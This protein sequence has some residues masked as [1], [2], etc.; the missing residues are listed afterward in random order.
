MQVRN[1]HHRVF[2]VQSLDQVGELIDS[3]AGGNDR[4]WPHEKWPAVR[5]DRPL[6]PGARGGHGL[7]RYDIAEYQPAN[8]LRCTFTAPTGLHGY[9]EWATRAVPG[10]YELR[11]SLIAKTTGWLVLTWPLIWRPLHDALI[12]DAL[13]KAAGQLGIPTARTPW[14]WYVRTLRRAAKLSRRTPAE[15]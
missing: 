10:G 14:S 15:V 4:L 6:G 2:A 1:V 7:I 8:L 13:D 3:I 12:E 11:H 9:H 5:F